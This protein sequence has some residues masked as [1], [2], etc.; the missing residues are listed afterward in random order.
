VYRISFVLGGDDAYRDKAMRVLLATLTL[1]NRSFF[2]ANPGARPLRSLS[3]EDEAPGQ[4]DWM[5]ASALQV[6]PRCDCEDAACYAAGW[7]QAKHGILAWPQIEMT[8]GCAHTIVELPDGRRFDPSLMIGR[9]PSKGHACTA[10]GQDTP[11]QRITFVTNLFKSSDVFSG[12]AQAAETEYDPPRSALRHMLH[13]LFLIDIMWLKRNPETPRLYE[14][15][16]RYES[17]PI[18]R[19]DWQDWPTSL[20]IRRYVDCEDLACMRASELCVKDGIQAYP[21]FIWRSRPSGANLYHIQVARPDLA[22]PE[23][24]SR[25]LGM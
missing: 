9:K 2:E 1:I 23:D 20:R 8:D 19:E 12:Q 16:L 11:E 15:G 24:P 14:S 4:D 22:E 13:A 18:G 10:H 17:E 25:L 6:L 7:L 5:D 21:S 3:Y